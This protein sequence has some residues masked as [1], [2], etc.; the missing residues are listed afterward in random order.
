MTI[1][2]DTIFALSTVPGRAGVAVVRI[3]GAAAALALRML[4]ERLP[5]PRRASLRRLRDPRS[6]EPLD[7]A[8]VLWMPEPASFTGEDT[9]ELH[10]HGG[11]AVV[12]GVLEALGGLPG[13]RPAEPGEMTRRA[14]EAGK[15]GLAEVEGIADLIE[16]E[17]PAQ[18]RMALAEVDGASTSIYEAW[19]ERIIDA[20]ALVEAAI[21]F[22]DE[23]DVARSSLDAG[24]AFAGTLQGE[25]ARHLAD[26]HRGEIVREGLRVVLAGPPNVGKSSLLN[27]LSRRDVA[28]VSAEP[29]TT[30]DVIEVR[31]QID[32]YLVLLADTAG[33]R[34]GAGAIER[35]GMRRTMTR[36]R[37]ADLVV[38]VMEAPAP[39][40][41][42]AD[43]QQVDAGRILVVL[44]KAD[45][46]SAGSRPA[47][48]ADDVLL[49]SAV[50]EDGTG[51][52][53]AAL[54]RG[55]AEIVGTDAGARSDPG[56][57]RARHRHELEQARHHLARAVAVDA[58]RAAEAAELVA[59]DLRLAARSLGRIT[60]RVD[61]EDVLDRVFSRFCIGK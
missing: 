42:P 35:E 56:V 52:L 38:W 13:L 18:R 21:D 34:D 10:L 23:A 4:T 31:L 8:L 41:V 51:P 60:G 27:A 54:S 5:K 40:P 47:G 29:G 26:G 53:L 20:S 25:I 24:L 17:T 22:S 33:L 50:T 15:L 45:L 11:R 6:G 32:G 30:R 58:Q 37:E 16:A 14:F 59:E 7:H 44:N 1:P 36:A 12:T 46:L 57:A 28:I 55:L 3:S 43:L 39:Q 19:R 49:V 9:V 2:A 48:I 61:V